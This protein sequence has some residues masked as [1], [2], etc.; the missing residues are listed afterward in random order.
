[1]PLVPADLLDKLACPRCLGRLVE[2]DDES[3]LAC[4]QCRVLYDV[5]DGIACLLPAGARPFPER[6]P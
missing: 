6:A 1:M 5:I 4:E 3:A 2:R